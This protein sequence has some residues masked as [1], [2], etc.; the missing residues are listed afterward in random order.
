MTFSVLELSNAKT[1][2]LSGICPHCSCSQI[3]KNGKIH[4]GKQRFKCHNCH[5]QFVENPQKKII[6]QE[7]R[8]LIDRLL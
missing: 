5:R 4:N 7:T 8:Q 1:N 6:N 2:T 3:V